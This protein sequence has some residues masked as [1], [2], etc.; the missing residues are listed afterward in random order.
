M[1]DS[2]KSVKIMG[3]WT[4]RRCGTVVTDEIDPYNPFKRNIPKGW[5]YV[6]VNLLCDDCMVLYT[7]L[8]TSFIKRRLP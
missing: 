6:D 8:L 3:T 5:E 7:D 1:N 4:C 2:G